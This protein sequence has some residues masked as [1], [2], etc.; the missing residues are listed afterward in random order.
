[1]NSINIKAKAGESLFDCR[2]EG[3][4]EE[5]KE[6]ENEIRRVNCFTQKK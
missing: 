6:I 3:T 2:I 1:M 4:A 5:L